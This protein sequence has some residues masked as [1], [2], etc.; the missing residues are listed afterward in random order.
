M[1]RDPASELRSLE[2]KHLRRSLRCLDSQQGSIV[3]SGE[4]RL[5]NFASNDYLGF[6]NE[7]EL[8]EHFKASLDKWGVGSGSSR[9][10]SGSLPPHQELEERISEHKKTA[11]SLCFSSGYAASVG[12]LTALLESDDWVI[13]DKLS[14]ASLIDGARLS[15]ANLRVFPHNQIDKLQ[16]LLDKI[17][18]KRKRHSRVIIVTEGTFSMDGDVCPLVDI[19]ALKNQ[20]EAWL[21]L[22][23]AHSFGV[24]GRDGSGMAEEKGVSDQIELQLGTFSKAAGLSGAYLA[25]RAEIVDLLI[26][27]A[28]SFIYSTAPPPALAASATKAINLIAG[29]LGK[30]RR[31]RLRENRQFFT[32]L[33]GIE[34]SSAIIPYPVG[35]AEKALALS[36]ALENTGIIAP[37]VRYPTVPRKQARLRISLTAKHTSEQ[38]KLL[39]SALNGK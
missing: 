18:Q 27:R 6:A 13:L 15:G 19:V 8:V 12:T 5:I 16:K 20:Y 39:A 29:D 23:E 38:L 34:T 25:A 33:T 17:Q 32:K 14:H 24:C 36:K 9:L 3:R 21:L 35:E 2:E 4:N 10:L 26:N 7:P 22:D 1:N 28:R 31:Q 11:R 37:A 30:L